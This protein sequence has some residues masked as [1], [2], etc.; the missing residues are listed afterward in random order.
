[1]SKCLMLRYLKQ[2]QFKNEIF[3]ASDAKVSEHDVQEELS[4]IYRALKEKNITTFLPVFLAHSYSTI[5]FKHE[6]KF[7][8]EEGATYELSFNIR[9]IERGDKV[10]VN[11]YILKSRLV[12]KAPAIE[13]G[14]LMIF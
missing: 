7:K 10:Y 12:F 3:I 9:Q 11:C 6:N 13:R 14:E 4:N 5:R 8:F 2:D 1:M